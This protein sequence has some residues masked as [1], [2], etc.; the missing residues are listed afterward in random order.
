MLSQLTIYMYILFVLIYFI[1][2]FIFFAYMLEICL[3]KRNQHMH[4]SLVTF[5]FSILRILYFIF[6]TRC[7]FITAES[8]FSMY[9]Y[10][11][12]LITNSGFCIFLPTILLACY[13]TLILLQ[14]F[15]SLWS[16]IL[17]HKKIIKV[18]YKS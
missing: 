12:F 11:Y 18:E 17:N 10:Y 2:C 14:T 4:D 5:Y 8:L 3:N 9:Y 16:W 6:K 13:G 1:A 7:K 15:L